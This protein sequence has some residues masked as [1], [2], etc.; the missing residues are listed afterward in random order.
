MA[1]EM[2][3]MQKTIRANVS[4]TVQRAFQ[5]LFGPPQG[6]SAQISQARPGKKVLSR[7][8]EKVFGESVPCVITAVHVRS[9]VSGCSESRVPSAEVTCRGG[10]VE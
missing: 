9:K 3:E 6:R 4:S 1:G 7:K 5:A 8:P 10:Q 2:P